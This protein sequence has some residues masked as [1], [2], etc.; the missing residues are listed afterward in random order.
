MLRTFSRLMQ[1]STGIRFFNKAVSDTR[2]VDAE[3]LLAVADK[4]MKLGKVR[5]AEG[6]Y[7]S[8]ID[9]YPDCKPAYQKLWGSWVSHRSLRVTQKELDR[10]IEKYEEHIGST[11]KRSPS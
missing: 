9:L 4:L 6:I 2:R 1:P 10:F 11:D 3:T 5:T 7:Q 8:T